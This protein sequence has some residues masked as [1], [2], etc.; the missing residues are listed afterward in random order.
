MSQSTPATVDVS[1]VISLALGSYHVCAATRLGTVQCWGRN[2]LGQLGNG[3]S[4]NSNLPVAV[5][6]VSTAVDV[7]L[8]AA[9][10]C[11]RLSDGSLRCWGFNRS[12]QLGNAGQTN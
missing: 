5:S 9:H 1:D 7:G 8:G 6:G 11:A 3:G 4:T 2:N 12:G 10:S